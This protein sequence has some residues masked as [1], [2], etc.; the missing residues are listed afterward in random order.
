MSARSR[1]PELIR[2]GQRPEF[3][4]LAA[5]E[6]MERRRY[7]TLNVAS[8]NPWEN[9]YSISLNSRLRA[10]FLNRESFASL[11][12]AKIL[13]QEYWQD[14]NHV[15]PHSLLDYHTPSE[16]AQRSLAAA[17]LGQPQGC[18]LPV[19]HITTNPQS[20]IHAERS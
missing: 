7:K 9:A 15:R 14:Y 1:A 6:W 19:H 11:L 5:Q 12:E 16:F 10:E 2:S 18:A 3:I 8:G 4:A 20:E 17:T 13:G